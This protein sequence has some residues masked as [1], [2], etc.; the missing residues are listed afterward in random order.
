[1]T[2][3]SL[4]RTRTHAEQFLRVVQCRDESHKRDGHDTRH[5][6]W[7]GGFFCVLW[8][9]PVHS[10]IM[11]SRR[12]S[13]S[14]VVVVVEV[15]SADG[16]VFPRHVPDARQDRHCSFVLFEDVLFVRLERTTNYA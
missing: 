8:K 13:E 9:S 1:M 14:D 16:R 11:T 3:V 4:L 10:Y 15:P 6:E 5:Q 12:R 2:A 7:R